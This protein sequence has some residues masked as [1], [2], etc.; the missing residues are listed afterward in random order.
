DRRA[1]TRAGARRRAS[2]ENRSGRPGSGPRAAGRRWRRTRGASAAPRPGAG[3]WA[4]GT[5][6]VS[7]SLPPSLWRQFF[8]ESRLEGTRGRDG[9]LLRVDPATELGVRLFFRD[10]LDERREAVDV[11]DAEPVV[12]GRLERLRNAAV[13]GEVHLELSDPRALLLGDLPFRHPAPE[14][15]RDFVERRGD[16]GVPALRLDGH[17]HGEGTGDVRRMEARMD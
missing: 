17:R 7:E 9:E 6:D 3:A 13:G 16:R 15:F 8:H 5:E 12:N 10:G 14:E 1:S 2:R 4:C 11:L